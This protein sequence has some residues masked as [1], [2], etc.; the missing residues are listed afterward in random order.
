MKN[1]FI[2]FFACFWAFS[3]AQFSR[4]D[5]S[6]ATHRQTIQLLQTHCA[7]CHGPTQQKGGFRVDDPKAL[8]EGG[9]S[10][11]AGIVPGKPGESSLLL[12]IT[13]EKGKRMPPKGP[14][15][16]EGDTK[17]IRE[18]IG[19][20]APWPSDFKVSQKKTHWAFQAPQRA[21]LPAV[22]DP[23]YAKNPIDRFLF[24]SMSKAGLKPNPR[25][26]KSTLIRRV[27][28]DLTG[29]P[30]TPE[31]VRAFLAD[32]RPDAYA[33]MVD[34]FLAS[35][36][37]GE[38]M[39]RPWLDLARYA[40]SKGFGSDPLRLYIWRYRDWVIDAFNKNLPYDQFTIEQLAG[41][42]IPGARTDQVLGTAFHRNTMTNTEGGT[43]NEEFR[44]AAVKDRVDTTMQVWMG[45]TAGCAKCHSHKFDPLS[46]REYYQIF[47][48]FNQTE[49]A[50]NDEDLPRLP[51]P[52]KDQEKRLAEID[53]K[54]ADLG[55]KASIPPKPT[56]EFKAWLL[57]TQKAKNYWSSPRVSSVKATNGLRYEVQKDGTVKASGNVP[58]TSKIEVN[59]EGLPKGTTGLRLEVLPDASFGGNGPGLAAHGNFV[60]SHLEVA[61]KQPH[62]P[63]AQFVRL[64]HQ[65][66]K[67]LHVAE[68]EVISGK[69]NIARKGKASQSSTA[70]DG[71]AHLAIDG[72]S[73]GDHSKGSVTHTAD[74]DP[75][76]WWQVDLGS[77]QSIDRIIV[78]NRTD[79]GTPERLAGAVL[80]L[81][82][83]NHKVIW[84]KPISKPTTRPMV[85]D[86]HE[87]SVL[88]LVA[89]SA[90]YEQGAGFVAQAALENN[91]K[92]GWAIG[93][94]IGTNQVL[95]VQL[96]EP[97]KDGS[98]PV[99]LGF[100]CSYGDKH[101][102]GKFRVL[103]TTQPNPSPAID[104]LVE[105]AALA[106]P[107]KAPQSL[108]NLWWDTKPESKVNAKAIAA[109]RKDRDAINKEV[110]TT[111]ILR[112]LAK[113]RQRKTKILIKGNFLDQG[114]EVSPRLPSA[115]AKGLE[116][117]SVNRLD[118]S[119]WLVSAENPLTSRVAVNRLWALIFGRG[120]VETEEDFG[121]MGQA[122]S[123]PELLDWL[124]V[125]YREKGW[126][127]KALLR[128][129]L[130][131]EA[132]AQSSAVPPEKLQK[133]P[134]NLLMSRAPR[135][136]LEAETVRD[137]ALALSGLLSPK[138]FGP[139]V[140]PAQPGGLW[141]AAFNGERTYPTSTGEDSRRRGVYTFLRRTVPHPA[142]QAFDAP[143]RESCTIRR[144]S[145]NT[146]LQA[147]VTLNDPNF[148]EAAHGLADR[149]VA[150]GG[151]IDAK[152][153]HGWFVCTAREASPAELAALSDLFAS[154]KA[155][156]AGKPEE[157]KKFLAGLAEKPGSDPAERAALGVVANVLLNLDS[158]LTR[159]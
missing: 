8:K 116:K 156:F 130:S 138:M 131:S 147:F 125:E 6:T 72:N 68:V 84:Q 28:L 3:G 75:D 18:W 15:L 24:A 159:N 94:K 44:I 86:V 82:D 99:K 92:M 136:R 16:P 55:A 118:F 51:T 128:L 56:P 10:G 106:N 7:E 111:P 97:L 96:A 153:R 54:L 87:G 102:L 45:L 21:A 4:A 29:L 49:D 32:T 117:A 13:G 69:T 12:R 107:E 46:H 79:G 14:P 115:F 89:P 100:D 80:E 57:E 41:D 88:A 35:P 146:P 26:D 53:A 50:D 42:M 134:K 63:K 98:G 34:G 74:G 2:L 83:A 129:I 104:N 71:P 47:A 36:G 39:A 124:A 5:E 30:P 90:T 149:M 70:Y 150:A 48:I 31:Q 23:N 93:G 113:E 81:R 127:T 59:L 64:R 112:E 58:E 103:A 122:P 62:A 132:Y 40:D 19:V 158:V 137:Q 133:D 95:A 37:Y 1:V 110:V 33:R 52:T 27:A 101:I 66:G 121:T 108:V 119:K 20:G 135:F 145:S 77:E 123:H 17:L 151:G 142:M 105:K 11:E 157:T 114:E 85:F 78:H 126:D 144:I 154:E 143:S 91:P 139:S 152:L 61:A 25:A 65:K 73:E 43:D 67:F 155:R 109:L 22:S 38:R 120:L 76:P 141:Q 140:Y 9:D 60:L 148:V